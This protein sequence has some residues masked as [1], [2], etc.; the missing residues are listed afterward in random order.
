MSTKQTE[1]AA[2]RSTAKTQLEEIAAARRVENKKQA[3]RKAKRTSESPAE[4]N[5]DGAETRKG[6]GADTPT[7]SEVRSWMAALDLSA[8]C[9]LD[10]HLRQIETDCADL[11]HDEREWREIEIDTNNAA[12]LRLGASA[13]KNLPPKQRK[14]KSENPVSAT[15]QVCVKYREGQVVCKDPSCR[16]LHV[17]PKRDCKNA[18]YMSMGICSNWSKC[19]SRH[20]WDERKWGD[21]EEAYR[22]YVEMQKEVKPK[23]KETKVKIDEEK[24]KTR[25][26]KQEKADAMI[27][28]ITCQ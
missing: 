15:K 26:T 8:L 21:K 11:D 27:R 17:I 23:A 16:K 18:S 7:E 24:S 5:D 12:L 25:K 3:Q 20:P 14:P 4:R 6:K 9:E 22:K 2:A 19:R 13:E 1:N 10:V 28:M